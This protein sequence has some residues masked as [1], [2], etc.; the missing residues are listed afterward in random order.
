MREGKVLPLKRDKTW[1]CR[2]LRG[3]AKW[4]AARV[5][6]GMVA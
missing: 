5:A 1:A 3:R 6:G 2:Y 4:M